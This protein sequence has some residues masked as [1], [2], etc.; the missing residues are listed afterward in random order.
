[1]RNSQAVLRSGQGSQ[2]ADENVCL[3][4]P[5]WPIA[6]R[7]SRSMAVCAIC[8]GD[9]AAWTPKLRR[10]EARACVRHFGWAS[11]LCG[12]VERLPGWHTLGL[13]THS[14]AQAAYDDAGFHLRAQTASHAPSSGQNPSQQAALHSTPLMRPSS[15]TVDSGLPNAR[16]TAQPHDVKPAGNT[17]PVN[18]EFSIRISWKAL[19]E[20]VRITKIVL[21]SFRLAIADL[22]RA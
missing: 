10:G 16:A 1:M 12:P 2:I 6:S 17:R 8:F 19:H 18:V 11:F 14:A 5:G 4:E 21:D 22:R 13:E 7:V 15:D 20:P 3:A 9:V